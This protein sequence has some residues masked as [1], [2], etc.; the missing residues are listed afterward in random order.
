M[1]EGDKPKLIIK[2]ENTHV[3]SLVEYMFLLP[4]KTN[5]FHCNCY[6]D[7]I[8]IGVIGGRAEVE[9]LSHVR[10]SLNRVPLEIHVKYFG[11]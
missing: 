6:S 5:I 1:R 4:K 8:P 9:G 10:W 7:I 11:K 3:D 2:G